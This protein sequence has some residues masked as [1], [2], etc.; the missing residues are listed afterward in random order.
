MAKRV[1]E[2]AKELGLKSKE[3]LAKAGELKLGLS[4]NFSSVS[5]EDEDKLKK[6][7]GKSPR[8]TPPKTAARERIE[9]TEE[10]EE[11]EEEEVIRR[12]QK[13]R[14]LKRPREESETEAPSRPRRKRILP[15][16]LRQRRPQRVSAKRP[17]PTLPPK[18]RK[19]TLKSPL[20]VKDLSQGLGIKA[21]LIIS[22]LMQ[23]GIMVTINEA[24]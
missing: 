8:Q 17:T 5:P 23:K 21:N 9:E 6:A 12:E 10:E 2:L 20:T 19:V 16:K 11:Q 15:T 18:Q 4:S 14:R 13:I 22:K 24:V 3:V 7:L 1:Y